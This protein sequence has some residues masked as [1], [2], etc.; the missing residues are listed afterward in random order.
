MQLDAEVLVDGPPAG[1]HR[2]VLEHR[3]A[4]IAVPRGLHRRDLQRA[5]QLVDHERGQRFAFDVLGHDQERLARLG[6]LLEQRQQVRQRTELRLVDENQRILE[7]DLHFFRVGHEIGRQVAAIELHAFH[8]L[9]RRLER[10]GFLDGDDAVLADLVH[11][12]GDD[13]ADGLVMVGGDACRP[14]RSSRR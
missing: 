7:D 8:D 6:D 9:E 12:F 13:P 1:Q 11:R 4:A 3:L 5:A 2:D 10:A 14:G